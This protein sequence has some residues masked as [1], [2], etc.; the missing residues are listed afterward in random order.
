M[1]ATVE[2]KDK[3]KLHLKNFSI[4][5]IYEYQISQKFVTKFGK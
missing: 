2:D 1:W 5:S 4:D 3:T